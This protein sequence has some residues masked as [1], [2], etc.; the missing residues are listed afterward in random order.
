MSQIYYLWISGNENNFDYF[1]EPQFGALDFVL[2]NHLSF[3]FTFP[4][5]IDLVCCTQ[6]E[7]SKEILISMATKPIDS[8]QAT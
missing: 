6:H 8:Y 5:T 2:I 7:I 3:T 4:V 1:A